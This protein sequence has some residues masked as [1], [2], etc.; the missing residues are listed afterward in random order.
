ME[1]IGFNQVTINNFSFDNTC[2][3]ERMLIA[4]DRLLTDEL[5]IQFDFH[6]SRPVRLI[7]PIAFKLKQLTQKQF[8]LID[9]RTDF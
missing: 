9:C 8:G 3:R 2:T 4:A 7:E 6:Y 1:K 5:P